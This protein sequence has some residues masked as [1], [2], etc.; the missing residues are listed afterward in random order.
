MWG[1]LYYKEEKMGTGRLVCKS[2]TY[3]YGTSRRVAASVVIVVS[4]SHSDGD[5]GVDHD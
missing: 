5:T 1:A 2:I 4:S 3:G